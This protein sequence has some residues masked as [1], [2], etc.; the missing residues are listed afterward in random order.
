MATMWSWLLG[1]RTADG[2]IIETD[3]GKVQGGKVE[4]SAA[5]DGSNPASIVYRFKGI[6]FAAP[7][8]GERRFK[9]P[10]PA[11]SWEGVLD[12]TTFGKIAVQCE[13][14]LCSCMLCII[15]RVFCAS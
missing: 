2:P 11:E 9:K 10:Q 15:K 8:V 13:Y 6:P 14:S 4:L 5:T 7:P 1:N 12:C 3:K